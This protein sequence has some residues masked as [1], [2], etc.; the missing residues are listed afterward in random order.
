MRQDVEHEGVRGRALQQ[1][2]AGDVEEVRERQHWPIHCAGSGIDSNG[3]MKPLSSIEGRK[4]KNDSCVAWNC[5]D[6][7]R[8]DE[9]EHEHRGEERHGCRARG[10]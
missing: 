5:V 2:A 6:E 1:H 4:K 7:R 10:R 8:Y 9:A 3:N